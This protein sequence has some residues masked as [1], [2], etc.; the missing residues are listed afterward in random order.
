[1]RVILILMRRSLRPAASSAGVLA[2][3]LKLTHSDIART[4][5]AIALQ[6]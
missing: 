3:A 2:D 4:A 6:N 1:M 5:I